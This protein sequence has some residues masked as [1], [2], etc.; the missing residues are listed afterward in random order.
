MISA[1][2]PDK[3]TQAQLFEIVSNH[4]M[5]GPCGFANKKSPCMVNGKC[6]RCFPKKFHGATIV[7]QDG[8]PVYRRRNYGGQGLE[9]KHG[10]CKK[11]WRQNLSHKINEGIGKVLGR[12]RGV[13]SR[14][15]TIEDNFLM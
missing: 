15:S 3:Q 7:D 13:G 5:H 6:I 12:L 10:G 8:F 11:N 9:R 14:H 1:E 2:I 4:M